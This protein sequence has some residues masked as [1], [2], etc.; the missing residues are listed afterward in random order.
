MTTSQSFGIFSVQYFA[1][2]S[3][4]LASAYKQGSHPLEASI[5]QASIEIS[6]PQSF[7]GFGTTKAFFITILH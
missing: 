7:L 4:S 1:A 2:F 5:S 3:H 6:Y